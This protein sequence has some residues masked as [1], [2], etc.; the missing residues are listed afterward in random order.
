MMDIVFDL[1]N[2]LFEWN[3]QRLVESLFNREAEQQEALRQIICH[4]D[5]HMLDKGT[6]SLKDAIFRAD[7]RCSLGVD[8]ITRVYE[9]TARNLFPIQEMFA[10]VED[11]GARGYNLYVLSNLQRHT[12]AYLSAA[13][14]IWQHFAGIVISSSIKSSKPEPMIYRY[15]IDTYKL[16]PGNTVF[17]DDNP[18]NIEAAVGFGLSAILVKSPAQG[19]KALYR[20]LGIQQPC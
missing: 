19:R 1:G 15:L 6:L 2:V 8:Q 13:Y 10:A 16:T 4:P 17:L 5:W 9:E 18:P 7:Q 14:D 12:Y 20:M 3:P 11:L